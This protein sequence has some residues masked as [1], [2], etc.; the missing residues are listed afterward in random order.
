MGMP[1]SINMHVQLDWTEC[2]SCGVVIVIP[3][4]MMTMLQR[5]HKSFYCINGHRQNFVDKSDYEILQGELKAVEAGKIMA[6][7]RANNYKNQVRAEKAAKTRIKN[8][9]AAGMCPCC[10][11]T[12]ENLARH[13]NTKHP[14]Y[15]KGGGHG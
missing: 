7:R 12:F 3:S 5:I 14:G 8:R 11:R 1:A 4:E 15:T 6:E 2:Y 9:V 13:M 10:N